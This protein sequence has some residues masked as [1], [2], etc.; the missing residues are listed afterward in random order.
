MNKYE[1]F[2]SRKV[3]TVGELIEKL[4][5]FPPSTK[6]DIPGGD[7]GGYDIC[8]K[9]YGEVYENEKGVT[10]CHMEYEMYESKQKGEI[11][12]EEYK[13]LNEED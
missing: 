11:T 5:T 9:P 10:I 1:E 7:C 2:K 4:Q 12:Y 8:N 3:S 6:L 13:E